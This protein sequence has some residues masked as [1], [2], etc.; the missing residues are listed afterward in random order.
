M[1]HIRTFCNFCVL[2]AVRKEA[3]TQ[4]LEVTVRPG[5]LGTNVY[6]RPKGQPPDKDDTFYT[7]TMTVI[8][9]KCCCN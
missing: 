3:E 4:G 1:T 6:V 5:G 8:Q 9:E 7:V 2:R